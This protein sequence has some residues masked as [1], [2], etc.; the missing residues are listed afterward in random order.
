MADFCPRCGKP[1][2][3]SGPCP[4]GGASQR[5]YQNRNAS[6][7]FSSALSNLP[8][9]VVGYFRDPVAT[10]RLAMEKRDYHGGFLMM[11][12]AVVFSVLSTLFVSLRYCGGRFDRVAIEWLVTGTVS[13]V[14]ALVGTFLLLY[15][16]TSIAGLR[17][18]VRG[19]IAL[20]GT[21]LILPLI[22]L[23]LS[24]VF[25][26][27]HL[28]IFQLFCV[29]TFAS[30]AVSFF[31]MTAQVLGIRLTMPAALVSVGGMTAAYL[32][33]SFLRDWLVAAFA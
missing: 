29:L 11:I 3:V 18:D 14:L 16:L 32:S 24:M 31:L 7:S 28:T 6:M 10:S 9:L 1:L 33:I 17:M 30:W 8:A 19:A 15:A 13:P 26:L 27:V 23:L 12:F 2:P 21:N 22:C 4:C 5:K 25:S 20:M